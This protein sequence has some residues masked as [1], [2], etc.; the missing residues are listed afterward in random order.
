MVVSLRHGESLQVLSV[1]PIV[2]MLVDDKRLRSPV[3]I[4]LSR[5]PIHAPELFAW[6][7]PYMGDEH[8]I[9]RHRYDEAGPIG[10][11]AQVSSKNH[12]YMMQRFQ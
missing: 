5:L 6:N 10:T 4:G 2:W 1:P 9:T 7:C 12:I 3:V 8:T 11:L